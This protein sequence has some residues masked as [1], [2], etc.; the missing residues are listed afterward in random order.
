MNR[1]IKILLMALTIA[2]AAA[3][4][5][6]A[7]TFNITLDTS[8]LSGPQI[9]AFGLTD[10]DGAADNSASL[11]SVAFGGGGA[12]AGTADCTLGGSLTGAGCSGDLDSG[13]ALNDSY[14]LTASDYTAIFTQEFNPGT[15]VS[16][17]VDVTDNFAGGAPDTFEVYVCDLSFD[18]YSDDPSTALVILNMDG[19]SLTPA[20]FE[21][22]AASAQ[23]LGVPAVG[24][25]PGSGTGN[26]EGT[27]MPEPSSLLLLVVG[28]LGLAG[29][30][31]RTKRVVPSC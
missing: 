10:G 19:T 28:L 12:I 16:F 7:D 25:G 30:A 11:S 20:S 14:V 9:M 23:G 3:C 29:I 22:F 18:C 15:S 1:Q 17:N 27:P 6:R 21:T 31:L 8:T 24:S 13:V 26:G 4:A 2:L 5:A